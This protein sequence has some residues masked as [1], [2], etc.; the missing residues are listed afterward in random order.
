[1]HVVAQAA[2]NSTASMFVQVKEGW[3]YVSTFAPVRT[4]LILF[5]IVSFMGVPYTVLMPVFTTKILHGGAHMLGFLMGAAGVGSIFAALSLAARKSVR[6]LYRVLPTVSAIFGGGL[7]AFSLSRTYWLSLV[8]MAVT[9]YGMMKAAAAANTVIQTIVEEDKR[10]RV[11]SYYM[12]AYMGASPL[13]SLLAG[14]LAP[15]I[16]APRTVMLCGIGCVAG[17][18]WFALQMPKLR[19]IIR[20]IYQQLGIIPVAPVALDGQN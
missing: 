4:V 1:M 14:S 12:M 5:A 18:V 2:K 7:I 8:L 9:G 13:G 11:M 17:A 16:G 20:P 15:V 6:G 10:G 3:T 19:P